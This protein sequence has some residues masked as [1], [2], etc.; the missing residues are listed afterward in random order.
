[1]MFVPMVLLFLVQVCLAA[2]QSSVYSRSHALFS[3]AYQILDT[4]DQQQLLARG[5]RTLAPPHVEVEVLRA[6][7]LLE[8]ASDLGNIDAT[9]RLAELYHVRV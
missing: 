1:M 2:P 6:V 7:K 8:Q 9:A 4:G 5:N 3:S